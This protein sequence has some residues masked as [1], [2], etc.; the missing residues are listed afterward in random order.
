MDR[1]RSDE[2]QT[3]E[4]PTAEPGPA[5]GD[6]RPLREPVR[7]PWLW[8][9]MAVVVLAGVPL[10]LPVGTIR[11]LV[12]GVPWWLLI[13]V[14]ATIAFCALTCWACLRAW[15]LAEPAEE[16]AAARERDEEVRP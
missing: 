14:G 9:A 7:N 2:P 12:G 5:P 1:R 8:A 3:A 6:A 11:P 10:Y 15:N 16:A 4:P 13:S